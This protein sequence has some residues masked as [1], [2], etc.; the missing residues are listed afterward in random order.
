[1]NYKEF[2]HLKLIKDSKVPFCNVYELEDGERLIIEPLFYTQLEGMKR[3]HESKMDIIID[4]II[5]EARKHK[6]VIF[7]ADYDDPYVDLP[8]YV[9]REMNDITDPLLIFVEDKSR[10]SDYGD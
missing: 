1:M 9:Y 2:N 7:T 10:G 4:A 5:N 3:L 8:G 6:N